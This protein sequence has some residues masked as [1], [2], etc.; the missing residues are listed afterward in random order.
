MSLVAGFPAVDQ[1]A[2]DGCGKG[3]VPRDYASYPLGALKFAKAAPSIKAMTDAELREAIEYKTANKAWLWNKFDRVGLSVKNQQ[4]SNYCWAH[5][6]VR[7]CEACY[8]FSGG[9]VHTLAAFDA[10]AV[11]K[12]GRNQGGSG[13]VAVEFIADRGVCS[14]ALHR[15]MDFDSSRSAEQEA[16]AQLHKILAYDDLD[17][18]DNR[19][20]YSYVANDIAV[21]VGIPIWSHEV[22]ITGLAIESGTIYPLIDNSWGTGYGNNGRAVLHGAYTR[23]DEA[24]AVREMTP[25]AE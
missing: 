17:P 25:S 2:P 14:E 11:I 9:K 21:T 3:Y 12:G 10:G 8:I 13:I 5:G 1:I 23:F 22:C 7:A 19:L 16:S 6:A 18:G 15:P 24:G 4:N 20:I